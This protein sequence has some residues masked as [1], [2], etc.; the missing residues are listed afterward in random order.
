[1]SKDGSGTKWRGNIAENFNRLTR[2]HERYRQ[3]DDRQATDDRYRRATA[4]NELR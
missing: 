2:E 1:M 4:Y 3:R